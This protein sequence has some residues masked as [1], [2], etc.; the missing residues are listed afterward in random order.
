MYKPKFNN[1][2]INSC[3]YYNL[4]NNNAID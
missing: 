2:L 1:Y 4:Y 3:G